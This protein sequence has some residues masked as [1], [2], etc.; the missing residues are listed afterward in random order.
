MKEKNKWYHAKVSPDVSC[1]WSHRH[2]TQKLQQEQHDFSSE[3]YE[4]VRESEL[5]IIHYFGLINLGNLES[6][7]PHVIKIVS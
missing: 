7:S 3:L 2:M 6:A 5:K 4:L 1:E